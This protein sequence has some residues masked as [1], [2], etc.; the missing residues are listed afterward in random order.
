MKP[1][2]DYG[3]HEALRIDAGGRTDAAIQ[4]LRKRHDPDAQSVLMSILAKAGRRADAVAW[5]GN[6]DA[7]QVNRLTAIGWRNL[8]AI[9]IEEDRCF[10]AAHVLARCTPEQESEC[11][12]ILYVRGL[13]RAASL[14]PDYA[15]EALRHGVVPIGV[16]MLEG[17]DAEAILAGAVADLARASSAFDA[18]DIKE[19]SR[20]AHVSVLALRLGFAATSDDARAD[21]K[22]EMGQPPS[23]PLDLVRLALEHGVDFD[24]EGVEARL[25]CTERL[26]ELSTEEVEARIALLQHEQPSRLADYLETKAAVLATFVTEMRLAGLRVEALAR[27]GDIVRARQV[28]AE[29]R[30]L[31]GKDHDRLSALV[32]SHAGLDPTDALATLA[33]T[34]GEPLDLENLC[35]A[36]ERKG[37]WPALVSPAKDLAAK[38]PNTQ[39]LLRVVVAQQ[40]SR[41]PDMAV[42]A[43]LDAHPELARGDQ[44]LSLARTQALL[45]AG[46]ITDGLTSARVL[47]A[48]HESA[49]A[50]VAVCNA[51]VLSGDWEALREVAARE[52]DR[53]GTRHAAHLAWIGMVSSDQDE[54]TALALVREAARRENVDAVT[55]LRCADVA[56]RAGADDEAF[57]WIHRAHDLSDEKGPVQTLDRSKVVSVLVERAEQTRSIGGLVSSGQIPIHLAAE[58]LGNGLARL[59]L[60]NLITNEKQRD[61]RRRSVLPLRAGSRPLSPPSGVRRPIVDITSLLL[62]AHL[63]ALPL[64]DGAFGE[65]VLPWSTMVM[66]R[67]E[68]DRLR[69]HQRSMVLQAQQLRDLLAA[70]VL[71]RL[72]PLRGRVDKSIEAEVGQQLA[73]LFAHASEAKG[74]VVHSAFISR[75][76]VD[77]EEAAQLGDM[78]GLVL[79]TRQFADMLRARAVLDQDRFATATAVLGQHDSSPPIGAPYT[80][81]PLFISSLAVAYLQPLGLLDA[82]GRAGLSAFVSD[83]VAEDALAQRDQEVDAAEMAQVLRRVREW[84]RNGL[85]AGKVRVA[86]RL[87]APDEEDDESEDDERS[88]GRLSTLKEFLLAP[89]CDGALV[90]DRYLLQHPKIERPGSLVPVFGTLDLLRHLAGNPLL[91]DEQ[92]WA[93]RHRLRAGGAACVPLDAEELRH[94][95]AHFTDEEVCE[96][97]ELRAIRESTAALQ[98][99]DVLVLPGEELFLS[100][101]L[102]AACSAIRQ[103]WADEALATEVVRR[104]ADWVWFHVVPKAPNWW[105]R[106]KDEGRAGPSAA[107]LRAPLELLL[108]LFVT[109]AERRKAS[110]SWLEE[111]LLMPWWADPQ[112]RELACG[113]ARTYI[114]ECGQRIEGELSRAEIAE[115]LLNQ[116][117][118]MLAAELRADAAFLEASGLSDRLPLAG[119]RPGLVFALPAMRGAARSALNGQPATVRDLRKG[120]DVRFE[121]PQGKLMLRVEVGGKV[122]E[123]EAPTDLLLLSPRLEERLEAFEAVIEAA[124]PSGPDPVYWRPLVTAEALSDDDLDA[125]MEEV[126]NSV[127]MR[128][129]RATDALSRGVLDLR[130]M[131][132]DDIRYWEGLCARAPG[133]ST[134]A[135][136]LA[137]RWR[138][139]AVR[140]SATFGT[141]GFR[142]AA[143]ANGKPG[144]IDAANSPPVE[145]LAQLEAEARSDWG[146]LA[147]LAIVEA[148]ANHSANDFACRAATQLVM[149]LA[150]AEEG[151]TQR[152]EVFAGLF[153]LVGAALLAS[154]CMAG[155]PPWWIRL[156]AL[157]QA[158]L[159]VGPLLAVQPDVPEVLKAMR[160]L[161]PSGGFWSDLLSLREEPLWR[162]EMASANWMRAEVLGRLTTLLAGLGDTAA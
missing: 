141:E 96:S 5:L 39:N 125:I 133:G 120:R 159:L 1:D 90:D 86:P 151:T 63:D 4:M 121:A 147:R 116:L 55:L 22:R 7:L 84:Y 23:P 3:L 127:P 28:L 129:A 89:E 81:G 110:R 106:L 54:G 131:A 145:V 99:R 162:P 117:P 66:L 38:I 112:F 93:L 113:V 14:Y 15:R 138:P 40:R 25:T 82:L 136:W 24:R 115:E 150:R 95:L 137:S 47:Y 130:L 160:E 73:L 104:R 10:D 68:A 41:A 144:F 94:H 67:Q 92:H 85:S 16:A 43:T 80:D 143:A 111:R 19:R 50:A 149:D 21:L 33:S 48:E 109:S 118:P 124:G 62:L 153:R 65:V 59:L 29:A 44:R 100:S 101:L 64:L 146:P 148:A 37:N 87:R 53:R 126:A 18:L 46:R 78:A 75:I 71:K 58:V 74:R 60:Q 34:T 152:V 70:G 13:A 102:L 20:N 140:L 135:D 155:Q 42:L 45:G 97:A 11:P 61:G 36:L 107:V 114:I 51:A 72:P 132:P 157:A 31:L 91:A 158:D 32:D 79:T 154:S 8:A 88:S 128:L 122:Q 105:H 123:L 12:D 35:R 142:L 49:G 161:S 69:H 134:Q 119:A 139:R 57:G 17:S 30:D 83:D 26:G 77:D 98:T 27:A 103:I 2:G 9:L 156:C 56:L 6:L 52:T 108:P 76:S